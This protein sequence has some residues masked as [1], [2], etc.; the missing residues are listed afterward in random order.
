MSGSE[1]VGGNVE[2]AV[3]LLQLHHITGWEVERDLRH[4]NTTGQMGQ[5]RPRHYVLYFLTWTL[6]RG[7]VRALLLGG[8]RDRERDLLAGD[9]DRL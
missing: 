6:Y 3:S 4:L 7:A 2:V 8:D 9:L 1:E 5:N